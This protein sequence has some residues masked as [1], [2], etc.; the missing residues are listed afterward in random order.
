MKEIT[1]SEVERVNVV[2]L[3]LGSLVTIFATRDF[4]SVF[5]FVF[6]SAIVTINF[7]LLRKVLENFILKKTL[8]K[9]DIIIRLPVKFI[10]LAAAIG[11][12]LLYYKVNYIA[13]M[14]GLSTVFLSI[15]ISQFVLGHS[16]SR[17]GT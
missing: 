17:E 7:R 8:T 12:V 16:A 2:I 6:A 5:S 10:V 15:L 14:V 11:V 4:P 3:V 13:F 9:K 1:V